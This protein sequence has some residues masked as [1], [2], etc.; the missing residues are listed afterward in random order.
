MSE[1]GPGLSPRVA[2]TVYG[3]GPGYGDAAEEYHEASKLHPATV[4]R[5]LRGI[6]ALERNPQLLRLTAGRGRSHTALPRIALP[7][8]RVGPAT[9]ERT[10]RTRR[11]ER[12]FRPEPL[13][14]ATLATLL[15][16]AYGATGTLERGEGYAPQELR[17]VPSAG[18]LYP[19]ELHVAA[20]RVEGLPR[21]VYR[22]EPLGHE[23]EQTRAIPDLDAVCPDPALPGD[24][25]AVVFV[26]A[27]FW[28]SRVKYGLRA[29]R[30]TL[31]EAGHV[32]QNLLLAATA[33]GLAA[34]VLGGFFDDPVD[35]LLD[36]DGV[37]ESVLVG[38]CV[39]L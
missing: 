2:P 33:L 4:A 30:F 12:L 29:Y 19:L 6:A 26:S 9:L 17:T 16:C 7:S 8:P 22:Y 18:A 11:S 15:W 37:D 39:G 35:R 23:L 31:L 3:D 10:L 27:T 38:A 32:L 13:D 20:L 28:R 25:A 36:L 34:V 5:E 24:A 21:R 1:P 14:Q